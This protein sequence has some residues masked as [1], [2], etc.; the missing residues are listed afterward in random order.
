MFLTPAGSASGSSSPPVYS[1]T[2]ACRRPTGF[3]QTS[4]AP[5][6]AAHQP[7]R[8]QQQAQVFLQVGVGLAEGSGG[9][10]AL[11][12]PPARSLARLRLDAS[13]RQNQKTARQTK[14]KNGGRK[15]AC[16]TKQNTARQTKQK[17]VGR[18]NIKTEA[19]RSTRLWEEFRPQ[20][21]ESAY[22]SSHF[23]KSAA[24]LNWAIAVT[25]ARAGARVSA[26]SSSSSGQQWQQQR[27]CA[28]QQRDDSGASG[29]GS[30]SEGGGSVWR[31]G[32][33]Q[34]GWGSG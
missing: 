1:R 11:A 3:P 15:T 9:W 16:Q 24:W 21:D 34:E 22:E 2:C 13:A 17:T 20:R 31:R 23:W 19:P 8:P 32:W 12:S 33:S 7:A 6:L 29:S 4:A 18:K 26:A 30:W 10:V 27:G 5:R 25:D 14:Q 28:W